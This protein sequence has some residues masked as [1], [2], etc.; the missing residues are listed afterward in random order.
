MFFPKYHCELN[1]IEKNWCHA[2]KQAR[3]HINSSIVKLRE[4]VPRSLDSVA[5]EM[6]DKFFRMCRDYVMAY[7]S[8]CKV[9]EVEAAVKKYKSHCRAFSVNS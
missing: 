7:K 8:G 9:I 2:K 3:Q 5:T 6:F 1:P 4:V